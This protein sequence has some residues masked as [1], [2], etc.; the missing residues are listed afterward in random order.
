ME[1]EQKNLMKE[2]VIGALIVVV[3]LIAGTFWMGTSVSDDNEEAV[4]TVSLL[5][6][7]ELAG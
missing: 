7:D 2:L 5:Y 1:T 6:L 4:R 3:I